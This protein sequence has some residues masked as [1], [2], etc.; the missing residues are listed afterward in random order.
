[1]DYVHILLIVGMAIL[2]FLATYLKTKTTF[3]AKVVELIDK[4]EYIFADSTKSGGVKFEWVVD[5]I[6]D[7]I[8]KPLQ[9][10]LTRTIVSDL[11]QNTFDTIEAYA[12]KQ[13][14]KII[15]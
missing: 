12:K 8:P 7:V 4:A 1:M 15:K 2:G 3:L 9:F 14:D 13:L 6:M 10:I 5:R 11:V